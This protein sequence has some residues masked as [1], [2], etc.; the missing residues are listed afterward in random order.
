MLRARLL[1]ERTEERYAENAVRVLL[2][3]AARD[4]TDAG[5]SQ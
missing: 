1:E 2:R 4:E 5:A 3:E